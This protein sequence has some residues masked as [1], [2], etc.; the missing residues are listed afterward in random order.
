MEWRKQNPLASGLTNT[1][2]GDK[3]TSMCCLS[4]VRRKDMYFLVKS[5]IMESESSEATDTKNKSILTHCT[6]SP[7]TALW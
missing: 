5:K 1:L 6:A 3:T 4:D 7:F 2:L